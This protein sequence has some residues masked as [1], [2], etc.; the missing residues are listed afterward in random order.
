MIMPPLVTHIFWVSR[1][2]RNLVQNCTF[3]I[4]SRFHRFSCGNCVFFM[5][6]YMNFRTSACFYEYT[7]P[8]NPYI[9]GVAEN[10]TSCTNFRYFV[11]FMRVFFNVRTHRT[12]FTTLFIPCH[13]FNN[14]TQ[15]SHIALKDCVYLDIQSL[16]T[17]RYS[18]ITRNITSSKSAFYHH[19][20]HHISEHHE[21]QY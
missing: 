17:V 3:C 8:I 13:I 14:T 6:V 19:C 10:L 9:S 4:L 20:V 15:F 16:F 7:P 5:H 21:E 12:C 1:K 11:L 2:M 18:H